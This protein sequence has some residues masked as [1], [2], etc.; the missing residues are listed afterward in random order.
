MYDFPLPDEVFFLARSLSKENP[1]Q[2]LLTGDLSHWGTYEA[3]EVASHEEICCLC[4]WMSA[5]FPASHSNQRKTDR[6]VLPG[7][8]TGRRR[9][10]IQAT[11]PRATHIILSF[12]SVLSV[13]SRKKCI[14]PTDSKPL[15]IPT[16]TLIQINPSSENA[17]YKA[18]FAWNKIIWTHLNSFSFL[19]QR[20]HAVTL[21]FHRVKWVQFNF[22]QRDEK[23]AH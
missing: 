20:R 7:T 3:C 1:K 19:S 2:L 22:N 23:V 6:L 4:L 16:L 9:N 15:H 12:F 10:V 5:S 21:Q 13:D 18:I 14:F 17:S 11:Y 8:A